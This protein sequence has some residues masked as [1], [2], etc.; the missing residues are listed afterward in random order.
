MKIVSTR[1]TAVEVDTLTNLKAAMARNDGSDTDLLSQL[2]NKAK[3]FNNNGW[4]VMVTIAGKAA[5]LLADKAR[6]GFGD[7][8]AV[9]AEVIQPLAAFAGSFKANPAAWLVR[10]VE[11]A[12]V[13]PDVAAGFLK[14]LVLLKENPS[15]RL[16][17]LKA[18]NNSVEKFVMSGDVKVVINAKISE[19]SKQLLKPMSKR[20]LTAQII[21]AVSF[22]T[23]NPD[24]F[25]IH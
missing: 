15:L 22:L 11:G 24:G 12:P 10:N 17:L 1:L 19:Y 25:S 16:D 8:A 14:A 7:D 23:H 2:S 21:R 20:D 5:S 3:Q 18:V 9:E 13:T 6:E 4:E